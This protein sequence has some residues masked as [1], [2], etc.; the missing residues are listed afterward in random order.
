MHDRVRRARRLAGLEA[1]EGRVRRQR[2]E[3]LPA[4]GEIG[5]QG[6]NEVS[7]ERLEID[8]EHGIAERDEMR[9]GV[10]AGLA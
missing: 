7:L 9:D 5:D 8:I 4:V 10:A 6:R 2:V 3:R 1:G